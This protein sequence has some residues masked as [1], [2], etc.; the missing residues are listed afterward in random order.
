MDMH[1]LNTAE[2]LMRLRRHSL[3]LESLDSIRYA[4]GTM[5]AMR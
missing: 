4:F 1:V 5:C 2:V 3:I